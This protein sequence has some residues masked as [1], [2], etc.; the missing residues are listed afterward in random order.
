MVYYALSL[1]SGML[2]VPSLHILLRL[3]YRHLEGRDERMLVA[4]EVGVA[5]LDLDDSVQRAAELLEL[6]DSLDQA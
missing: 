4:S 6:C 2:M 3:L 5:F 1:A